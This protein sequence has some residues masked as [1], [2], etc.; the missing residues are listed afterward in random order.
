MSLFGPLREELRPVRDHLLE[1]EAAF[2]KHGL[3][4]F[5]ADNMMTLCRVHS[6]AR[7]KSFLDALAATAL[8]DL[9]YDKIWKVHTNS[10]A[11]RSALAPP[12]DF[13]EC[14]VFLGFYSALMVKYLDFGST[15]KTL[16]LYDTFEGLTP[17]Y[18][19]AVEHRVNDGY[20]SVRLAPPC[21]RSLRRLSKRQGGKG[22]RS[23]C[24]RQLG[25][26]ANRASASRHECGRR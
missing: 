14:G 21:R 24:A 23:P 5:M 1:V 12:G 6:F 10:W 11:C 18:S 26:R 8:S 9:D 17:D 25:A 3:P 20:R 22:R 2:K 13:V 15:A 19:T 7:D 4:T 16:Y